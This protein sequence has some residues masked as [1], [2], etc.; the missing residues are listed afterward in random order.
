MQ[1]ILRYIAAFIAAVVST[2][3]FASIFSTQFVVAGL[4]DVGA[5]VPLTTRLSMTIRDL[6]II[7]TLGLVT[8]ACFMIGFLVAGVCI[9]VAGGSRLMWYVAAGGCALTCT[10][11]LMEWQLQLTPIAG[12]RTSLGFAF[13]GLAGGLGGA[14]FARLTRNKY[15]AN[16]G[17]G[18]DNQR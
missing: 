18:A 9:K 14:I 4:Q 1:T 2:S 7:E 13:Q 10:L 16:A 8:A 11:L 3:I 17:A 15:L 12:A 5:I 6:A